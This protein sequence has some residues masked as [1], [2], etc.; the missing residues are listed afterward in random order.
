MNK[1]IWEMDTINRCRLQI[2]ECMQ[3]NSE[4]TV[5]LHISSMWEKQKELRKTIISYIEEKILQSNQILSG[6]TYKIL[7]EYY[8]ETKV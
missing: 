5:E 3:L 7:L 6:L 4:H 1:I 2:N 8:S